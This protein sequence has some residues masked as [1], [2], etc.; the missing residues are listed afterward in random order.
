MHKLAN[1]QNWSEHGCI[2]YDRQIKSWQTLCPLDASWS[3]CSAFQDSGGLTSAGELPE[4]PPIWVESGR[5]LKAEIEK[6]VVA[7][8]EKQEWTKRIE[9]MLA[10]T[11]IQLFCCIASVLVL[12]F[13]PKHTCAVCNATTC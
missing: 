6:L 1:T 3:K 5:E 4:A 7:L 11:H 2:L 12:V 13:V 10:H 8:D 9:V